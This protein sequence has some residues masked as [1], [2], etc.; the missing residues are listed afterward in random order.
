[1]LGLDICAKWV[2]FWGECMDEVRL[3]KRRRLYSLI[4]RI[5]LIALVLNLLAYSVCGTVVDVAA[6]NG[7]MAWW[8]PLVLTLVSMAFAAASVFVAV[9]A[10]K[11]MNCREGETCPDGWAMRSSLPIDRYM[12]SKIK[13]GEVKCAACSNAYRANEMRRKRKLR[14]MRRHM[15]RYF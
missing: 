15:N 2:F 9:K 8:E 7:I 1:M 4:K 11:S 6:R 12:R 10:H 3:I 13:A 14:G 5:S